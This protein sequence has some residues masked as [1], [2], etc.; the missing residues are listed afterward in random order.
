MARWRLLRIGVM[1]LLGGAHLL[2][3]RPL[4]D[5][6]FFRRVTWFVRD[7]FNHPHSEAVLVLVAQREFLSTMASY[8]PRRI[9]STRVLSQLCLQHLS[10]SLW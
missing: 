6:L 9:P 3:W 5:L 1:A 8:R 7:R 2:L 10:L 4:V